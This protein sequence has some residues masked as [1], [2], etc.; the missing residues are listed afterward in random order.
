VAKVFLASFEE[1]TRIYGEDPGV[2]AGIVRYEV[3]QTRWLSRRR[4]IEV[5]S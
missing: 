2:K 5:I 3:H 1:T 4:S